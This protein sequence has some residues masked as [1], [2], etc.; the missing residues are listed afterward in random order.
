VFAGYAKVYYVDAMHLGMA[1]IDFDF[2]CGGFKR[3]AFLKMEYLL[4]THVNVESAFVCLE[5]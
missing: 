4:F 3:K 1:N 2:V 5:L